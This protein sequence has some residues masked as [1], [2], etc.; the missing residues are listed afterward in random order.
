M[1]TPAETKH[2]LRIDKLYGMLADAVRENA[3]A[4]REV[5][6]TANEDDPSRLIYASVQFA[7]CLAHLIDNGGI[8]VGKIHSAFG[9]PGDWGYTSKIGAALEMI[10]REYDALCVLRNRQGKDER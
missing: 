6:R 8:D 3:P 7:L 2:L 10:Y 4:V 5:A 9:S 1:V